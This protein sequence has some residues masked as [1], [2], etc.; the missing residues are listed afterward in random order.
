MKFRKLAITSGLSLALVLAGCSADDQADANQTLD[1]AA[2][3]ASSVA[4]SVGEQAG[5]LFDDAK[6]QAF[7]VAF[8]AQFG[9][10]AENR[11]DNA[12]KALLNSTCV[13][14]ASGTD[15]SAI[16]SELEVE[17]AS[18]DA[19]PSTEQAQRIYDQAK[20]ACS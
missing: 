1:N 20:L 12:I 9:A 2:G 4:A 18:G 10:L 8:R 13:E 19:R 17:A 7:V 15:E 6:V 11:D 3:S 14:I 5:N 16:V